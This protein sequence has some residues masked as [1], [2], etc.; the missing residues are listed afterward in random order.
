MKIILI[1]LATACLSFL[2]AAAE[3]PNDCPATAEQAMFNL[4]HSGQTTDI[5]AAFNSANAALQR[6]PDR[7]EVQGLASEILTHVAIALTDEET[8]FTVWSMAYEAATNNHNAFISGKSPVVKL[9][10]GSE[11]TLYPYATVNTLMA[12]HISQQLL[13]LALFDHVH[14]MFESTPLTACPYN[15]KQNRVRDEALGLRHAGAR[16]YHQGG[17]RLALGRIN[18]LHKVCTEQ[19]SY[20]TLMLAEL[21]GASS[22]FASQANQYDFAVEHAEKSLA[23]YETFNTMELNDP[24]DKSEK[25]RMFKQLKDSKEALATAKYRRDLYKK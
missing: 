4:K 10:D 24:S 12:N 8:K 13:E 11:R 3:T 19:T 15:K 20:L 23:F 21:H 22:Y 6:C 9:S 5:Q 16:K 17:A 1:S 14:P 18:R 25:Q 7:S 2:T